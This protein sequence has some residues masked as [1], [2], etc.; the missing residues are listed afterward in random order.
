MAEQYAE[1]VGAAHIHTSAKLNQG[2]EQ[3]FETISERMLE[4][5]ESRPS[6]STARTYVKVVDDTEEQKPK[7]GCCAGGAHQ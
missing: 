4:V 5:A 1:S 6:T 3:V 2:I 7:S